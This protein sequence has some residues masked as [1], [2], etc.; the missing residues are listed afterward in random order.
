MMS[1]REVSYD[2]DG[3]TMAAYL[4]RPQGKAAGPAVLIGH[5]GVGLDKYQRSRADDLA[6]R[7]YVVLAMDYHGGQLF[8]GRPEAML[9]R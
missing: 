9:A 8:F 5:D 6:A 3:M 4:A 7:G 1:A 2:V